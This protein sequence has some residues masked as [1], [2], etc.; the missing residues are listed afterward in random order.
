VTDALVWLDEIQLWSS[1]QYPPAIGQIFTELFGMCPTCR[2]TNPFRHGVHVC[3]TGR[4]TCELCGQSHKAV[5]DGSGWHVPDHNCP[6][7]KPFLEE[8]RR[9]TA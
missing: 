7:L 5:C 4:L 2:Q 6:I 1:V 9:L 3:W 8:A